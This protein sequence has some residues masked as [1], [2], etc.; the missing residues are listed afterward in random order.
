MHRLVLAPAKMVHSSYENPPSS[1]SA[2]F[3]SSGHERP[4]TAVTGG[5]HVYPEMAAA[6]LWT[7]A[8]DLGRWGISIIKSYDGESGGVLSPAM[9][10]QM[11]TPQ[12]D[13]GSD[14]SGP[15]RSWWGL[16]VELRGSGDSLR[17]AHGGRDEG[18]V[19]DL[20]MWPAQRKGIVVMTNGVSGALMQEIERAFTDQYGL[21]TAPRME[22]R[23]ASVP[24]AT[25]DS[26]PGEYRITRGQ[27][28]I[29]IWVTRRG[30]DLWLANTND[31]TVVRLLPQA[32][33]SFF[34]LENGVT[35]RFERPASNSLGAPM[36]LVRELRGQRIEALRVPGTTVGAR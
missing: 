18:F 24:P 32:T 33:D 6:G 30:S 27:N 20:I 36:K 10:R 22:K 16:G 25:L 5:Y 21:T 13:V 17:S 28:T 15:V 23:L 4:D 35:W 14:F 12:V 2:G 34:D 31:P 26:L 9:A 3:L 29:K 7:T 11:L 19:A 1:A 8:S